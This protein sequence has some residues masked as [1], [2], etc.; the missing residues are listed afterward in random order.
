[1]S[2]LLPFQGKCSPNLPLGTEDPLSYFNCLFTNEFIDVLVFNNNF[3]AHQKQKQFEHCEVTVAIHENIFGNK[4]SN[5]YQKV[6]ILQR[7]LVR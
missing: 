7:L 4:Y 3:Y 1:M 2:D 5:K 6:S